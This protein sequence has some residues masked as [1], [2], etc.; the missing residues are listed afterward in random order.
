MALSL[1]SQKAPIPKGQISGGAGTSSS[2]ARKDLAI[3]DGVLTPKQAQDL[4]EEVYS[5][6]KDLNQ[7]L[8]YL[9]EV[10]S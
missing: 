10:L 7:L 8:A 5:L 2:N 1:P 9:A 3:G 4:R 6:R